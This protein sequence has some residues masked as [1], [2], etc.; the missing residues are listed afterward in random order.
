MYFPTAALRLGKRLLGGL[1]PTKSEAGSTG[2]LKHFAG[3][4]NSLTLNW[5]K[6]ENRMLR[7]LSLSLGVSVF[8]L[9]QKPR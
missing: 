9:A 5:V 1:V 6:L 4:V 3:P 2:D 7:F 8:A